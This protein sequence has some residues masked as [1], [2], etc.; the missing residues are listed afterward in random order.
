MEARVTSL[1]S[2]PLSRRAVLRQALGLSAAALAISAVGPVR[3]VAAQDVTAQQHTSQPYTVTTNLNLRTGPGTTYGVILVMPKGATVTLNGREQNGFLSVNYKG[4][5]GWAHHDYIVPAGSDPVIIGTAATTTALNLR[6]GPSSSHQVLRVMAKGS[7]VQISDTVQNG[8]R[9][10]IHQGLAGWAYDAYLTS[11]APAPQ[12]VPVAKTT[13]A[14]NFRAAPSL[15]AKIIAVIPA[16]TQV[17]LQAGAS[18]G[19]REVGYNGTY[20][21][22]YATYLK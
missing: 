12:P 1:V 20:G 17:S 18:N 7:A 21:W 15:S 14:V 8:Y 22:V 4:T 13:A 6:S 9:Y 2:V 11:G 3:R 10:V 19:F 5:I 16:G